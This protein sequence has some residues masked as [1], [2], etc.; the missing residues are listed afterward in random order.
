MKPYERQPQIEAI[1]RREGEVSV[2]MLAQRFDVSS[3]TIRRDLGFLAEHGRIQK[4]HGGARRPKLIREPSHEERA[5]TAAAAKSAIGRRLA[6]AVTPGET[7]FID[8]GS[9]TLA[10]ADALA[11]IPNLTVITN[12]CRLAERLAGTSQDATIHLLGGR[13][14]LDN[15]QTTGIAVIEQLQAFRAD[16][17]I[18]TVAAIDPHEGAMDASLDEAQIARAMIRNARSV[19][20]LADSGK[21][22]RQAAYAVCAAEEIDLIISDGQLD[23]AHKEA[24]RNKGVELW[25]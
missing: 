19:T 7:L 1:I 8:T 4:V 17:A 3:E 21:F 14:G 25:T 15:A 6:D 13:Y 2:E 22:G 9:T 24:L 23:K 11:A 16:R 5:T 12:S 18:L 10:A 20:I